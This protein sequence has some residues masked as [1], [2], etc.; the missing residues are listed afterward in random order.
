MPIPTGTALITAVIREMRILAQKYP[1]FVY[2]DQTSL[3]QECSYLGASQRTPGIGQPCIVGQALTNL[4]VSRHALVRYE[5]SSADDL[6]AYLAFNGDAHAYT[7]DLS[8]TL[9]AIDKVQELQD[10]GSSWGRAITA[11]DTP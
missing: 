4:G 6:I 1:D 10:T 8:E 5:G 7:D 11:L 2:T 9:L 3:N